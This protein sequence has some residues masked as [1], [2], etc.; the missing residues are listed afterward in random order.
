[1]GYKKVL[2]SIKI[3]NSPWILFVYT[4]ELYFLRGKKRLHL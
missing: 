3:E 1:M 4:T 2:I